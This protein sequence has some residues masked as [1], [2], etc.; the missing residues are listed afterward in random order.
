MSGSAGAIG[1]GY[2]FLSTLIA[3][4]NNV[5]QQL[6]TLTE[7]ASSGLV[8]QTYAGLGSSAAVSLSLNP[9]LSALQTY[10]NNI[11]EATAQMQV[12]QTAMTQL[13]QIAATF[14]GDGPNLTSTNSREIDS[15]A[16]ELEFG[17]FMP[18]NKP[19]QSRC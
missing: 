9:Q 16:S 18:R 2:G 13:Q 14:A 6:N 1:A 12:T 17:H 10:Q 5:H 8:A 3:N 7:Q 11:G 4:A 15:I 19:Y